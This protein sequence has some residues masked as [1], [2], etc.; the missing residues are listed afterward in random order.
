MLIRNRLL[1]VLALQLQPQPQPQ[2][3]IL[4]NLG[5]IPDGDLENKLAILQQAL[6]EQP[7][8]QAI[9]GMLAATHLRNAQ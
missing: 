2:P 6:I 7:D 3:Q 5:K 1:V 4:E 9:W 8:N